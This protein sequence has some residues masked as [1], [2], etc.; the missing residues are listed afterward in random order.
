MAVILKAIIIHK[1]N[2]VYS[3]I[4]IFTG[5]RILHTD[6]PRKINILRVRR[7][8]DLEV[9]QQLTGESTISKAFSGMLYSGSATGIMVN[10]VK[11]SLCLTN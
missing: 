3:I 1:C 5:I 8:I 6:K 10:K 11:L 4:N 7:K 2:R 9:R